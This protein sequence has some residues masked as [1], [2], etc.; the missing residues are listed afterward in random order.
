M[1]ANLKI[2]I[3]PILALGLLLGG[4]TSQGEPAPSAETGATSE[5]STP[6]ATPT[7]PAPMDAEVA[8][9]KYLEAV[10]PSN[11]ATDAFGD[12]I[13]TQDVAAITAAANAALEAK[14]GAA[15]VFDD[16][17]V[18]WPE[19]VAADVLVVRDGLLGDMSTLSTI[20]QSTTADQIN[21]SRFPDGTAASEA[22]QR[23]RLRLNLSA[24]TAA[25]C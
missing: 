17:S 21:G 18:V 7:V 20:A 22:S 24:D 5:A 16:A 6:S 4:C 13:A 8:G 10:C 15:M 12:A 1:R 2:A 9:K 11:L 3:V 25:Q 19:N 14:R 23:I